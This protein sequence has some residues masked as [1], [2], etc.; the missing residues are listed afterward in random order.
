[1]T[2]ELRGFQILLQDA[3]HHGATAIERVHRRI[4]A[5][6][7][8]IVKAI[9]SLA[10]PARVVGAVHS[11]MLTLVYASIRAVNAVAGAGAALL[12]EAVEA[13]RSSARERAGEE[14]R[15]R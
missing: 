15:R 14:P 3:I 12:I 7:F 11:A 9:P 8:A 10:A 6:P 13:E 1:M 4:A 2:A 5:R